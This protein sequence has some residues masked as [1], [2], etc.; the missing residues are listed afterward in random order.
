MNAKGSNKNTNHKTETVSVLTTKEFL[1]VPIPLDEPDDQQ[2][3][4]I[5]T[6][7]MLEKQASKNT[8]QLR[9]RLGKILKTIRDKHKS[10]R[11]WQKWIKKNDIPRCR[12]TLV[13][14]INFA[15][16]VP[17]EEL[18]NNESYTD[19]AIKHKCLSKDNKIR[20]PKDKPKI[21]KLTIDNLPKKLDDIAVKLSDILEHMPDIMIKSK[22]LADATL[23]KTKELAEGIAT[24]A[25][26]ISKDIDDMLKDM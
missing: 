13:H 21:K 18:N 16:N 20:F 19:L 23:S 7:C 10:S 3:L 2:A 17:E 8:K 12:K 5:Q 15:E 24:N 14:W 1:S 9:Y 4:Y 25:L 11:E 22:I 26:Q 6:G